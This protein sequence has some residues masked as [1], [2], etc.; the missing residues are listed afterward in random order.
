M[1][2][3][4]V[5]ACIVIALVL[6]VCLFSR[7][8]I[9][10]ARAD[11]PLL[12]GIAAGFVAGADKGAAVGF[13]S[14]VAFDLLLPTPLGLSALTY[15]VVGYAAGAL[16]GSVIRAA[17]WIPVVTAATASAAG[18]VLYAL[19]G[20]VLGQA[21][22]SGVSLTAIVA[23]VAAVNAVLAPVAVWAMRWSLVDDTAGRRYSP[24]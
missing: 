5:A 13:A 11:V 10:G 8:P 19:V 24:R 4:R 17:W 2:Q 23:V 15:T 21:T 7:L 6:Q 1:T 9:A 22:L 14:G 18:V 12:L 16:G 20:E 3:A